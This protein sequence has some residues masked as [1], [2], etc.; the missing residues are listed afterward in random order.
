MKKINKPIESKDIKMNVDRLQRLQIIPKWSHK[1]IG[2]HNQKEVVSIIDKDKVTA[3]HKCK[4]LLLNYFHQITP[5]LTK[6]PLEYYNGV[7]A[8]VGEKID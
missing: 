8:Y 5:G 6:M 1:F 3:E 7:V 4:E 2:F